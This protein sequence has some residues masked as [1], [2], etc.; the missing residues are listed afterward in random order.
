MYDSL[1]FREI[2]A[3]DFE[4]K[5]NPGDRPIPICLVA[6]ELRSGRI[7]RQWDQSVRVVGPFV[8]CWSGLMRGI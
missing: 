1:P 4:F 8:S 2:W 7:I 6:K 5:A 3:V